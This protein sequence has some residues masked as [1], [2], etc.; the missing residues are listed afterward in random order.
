LTGA[1]PLTSFGF[2][3]RTTSIQRGLAALLL[4]AGLLLLVGGCSKSGESKESAEANVQRLQ[5][6]P[7]A[8]SSPVSRDEPHGVIV[9]DLARSCP[10]CNLYT[11]YSLGTAELIDAAGKVIRTWSQS[12]EIWMHS[13][14]LANGD[15]LVVGAGSVIDPGNGQ[16]TYIDD[17]T[18]FVR[19]YDWN[20]KALWKR[21]YPAHHDIE[22]TPDGKLLLLGLE[23]RLIPQFDPNI[24]VRD[25][26][27]LLLEPDGSFIQSYSL[28][29]AIG[30]NN[31]ALPLKRLPPTE[32]A[33]RRFTDLLHANSAEW[34]H[35][36]DLEGTHPPLYDPANVLV[37]LRHQDRV[38]L[39]NWETREVVWSWGHD[40]LSAPHDARML[41][42]GNILIFDNGLRE[43]RSRVV[44]MDPRRGEIVWQYVADPPGSFFSIS[45]GSAQRLPNGNTLAVESDKGR[46][47][48]VTPAGEIVWEF[49]CPHYV[50]P[51]NRAAI[52]HMDRFPVS[53]VEGLLARPEE[54]G[55]KP[56]R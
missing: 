39:F 9:H 17:A 56:G 47:I 42:N 54:P 1:G 53:F 3:N 29:E 25:E 33:G 7:Y 52:V 48:E 22:V 12:G 27:L 2:M 8:G 15:L 55:A 18:R 38:A 46:A 50:S 24:P 43:E 23:Y 4:A 19:R 26:Q 5:A 14:L 32:E 41:A 20:G 6:L 16:N 49:V 36:E 10:G 31:R 37:C 45:K 28:T 21:S 13:E 51:G 35:V 34:M 40:I 44:E 11:I 30:R